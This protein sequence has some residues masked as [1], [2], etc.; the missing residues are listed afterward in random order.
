MFTFFLSVD[1][2]CLSFKKFFF[3]FSYFSRAF[4]SDNPFSL[5]VGSNF[6]I[7][8]AILTPYKNVSSGSFGAKT[9]KKTAPKDPLLTGFPSSCKSVSFKSKLP[10]DAAC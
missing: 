1:K 4:S 7:L 10:S 8:A 2:I 9:P 3:S 5:L 6:N